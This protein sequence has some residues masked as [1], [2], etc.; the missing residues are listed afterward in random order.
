MTEGGDQMTGGEGL[1][2]ALAACGGFTLVELLMVVI[3][4]G[5]IAGMAVPRFVNSYKGARL[6]DSVRTI[7]RIHRFARSTSVLDQKASALLFDIEKNTVTLLSLPENG[8]GADRAGFLDQMNTKD[9]IFD[10]NPV[11]D[12][13]EEK[14]QDGEDG[15]TE[16]DSIEELLECPL[17]EGIKIVDFESKIADQEIEGIYWV[18]YFPN[19]MCDP[20]KIRVA[21]ADGKKFATIEVDS[22]S[23][24]VEVKYE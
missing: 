11:D 3:I 20:Y 14:V 6:R 4:A 10:D 22:I 8:G 17:A 21:G 9:S 12:E 2:P 1:P 23:G 16:K 19:G 24:Q 5:L 13:T 18:N 15:S 7:V